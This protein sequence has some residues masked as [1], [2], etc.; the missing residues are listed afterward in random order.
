MF[1]I[2]T[3]YKAI[4]VDEEASVTTKDAN[5][6]DSTKIF[7]SWLHEK[8]DQFLQT[9]EIDLN[10]GINSLDTVLHQSMYFGLSMS[11]VGADFR[12]L[13]APIFIKVI[14]QNFDNSIGKVTRQFEVDIDGFTLI[15]K[16][17][18]GLTRQKSLTN[19]NDANSPPET[20]LD[21]QPL[22]AYCNGVLATF[23]ELRLCAP[24]AIANCVTKTIQISLENV[25]RHIF[26][27]YRQ[28]QQAFTSTERDNFLKLCSCFAYELIPYLQNVIHIIFPTQTLAAHLGINM[29]SIQKENL[30]F[31]LTKNILEPL[32]HLLPDKS[33]ST[34]LLTSSFTEEKSVA[35]N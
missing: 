12:G 1:N 35:A 11:R 30:T 27:F 33:D 16:F 28:E 21:F 7:Y 3:Q 29:M 25:S 8:I 18:S 17:S 19:D 34:M 6:N 20:L 31:L 24:I 23:N 10:L 13:M 14:S 4:F 32:Q 9:L 26:A 5:T 15:N 2:I 22:A